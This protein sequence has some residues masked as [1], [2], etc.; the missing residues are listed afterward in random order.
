MIFEKASAKINLTLDILHKRDDGYHEV[1][2]VMTMIDLY[3]RLTFERLNENK[4]VIESESRYV[5][6][7]RRNL[8]YQAAEL[9]KKKTNITDGV[10]IIIDKNIPVAAGLAG[11]SSDAAATIRGM[12]RLFNQRLTSKE[13]E[14]I[15]EEI[16][17]DVPFCIKGG[18]QLARGRGEKLQEIPPLPSC[19]VVL[20]KPN[21]GVS[22]KEVY[23]RV[24]LNELK[25]PK[26]N[27]L[28]S[29]LKEE[30]FNQVCKYLEN[31]LEPITI[32]MHKEIAHIKE[33]MV[34]S[35]AEGVLMSG[36]GPTV[37]ALT[38]QETKAERIYN[39]LRGFCSEVYVVRSLGSS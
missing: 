19:Y 1:E 30:N 3:D 16:G 25:H 35:D 10:R 18:T 33:R 36:S 21:I 28:L 2:M 11:G 7:D 6:D 4:I 15:G 26:T 38:V 23:S 27:S 17:S 20:A 39:S 9:F 37:F 31:V 34:K 8:A 13:M 24:N 14:Q 5:P 32:D 22:T 29:A 12:N